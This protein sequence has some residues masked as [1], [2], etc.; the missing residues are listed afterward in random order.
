L[1]GKIEKTRSQMGA[2][3]AEMAG[4][5]SGE[6]WRINTGLTRELGGYYGAV[7][8]RTVR[9]EIVNYNEVYIANAYTEMDVA[10]A[11]SRGLA[12]RYRRYR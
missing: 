5:T 2:V 1:S 7:P 11:V 8:E 10:D 9:Q 6:G 3:S 12:E 4:L